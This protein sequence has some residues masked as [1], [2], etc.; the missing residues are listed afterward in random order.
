M[1]LNEVL[2]APLALITLNSNMIVAAIPTI[3][4]DLGVSVPYLLMYLVAA[5]L[6]INLI[7]LIPAGILGD[8]LGHK[9]ASIVGH[10]IIIISSTLVFGSQSIE[11][12]VAS[13]IGAAIGGSIL[14]PN[15]TAYIYSN[16]S[17]GNH[18]NNRTMSMISAVVGV[19][20][21]AGP[22]LGGIL[23]TTLGW[24]SILYINAPFF[25]LS[26][27]VLIF[28]ANKK[29]Q[30][31]EEL[32]QNKE[33]SLRNRKFSILMLITTSAII[34]GLLSFIPPI[35]EQMY[36]GK[37][38][39]IG[40]VTSTMAFCMAGS[41]FYVAKF[42]RANS[43]TKLLFTSFLLL[44][45]LVLLFSLFHQSILYIVITCIGV[46]ITAGIVF[47]IS[48]TKVMEISILAS[49]GRTAGIT[50]AL[51]YLGGIIGVAFVSL[52]LK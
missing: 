51:R 27:L 37:A 35:L 25:I 18:S 29:K 47:S 16:A 2:I 23:T 10:V 31:Y 42:T 14:V 45:F 11:V 43:N 44:I 40:A 1:K 22:F 32:P 6:L 50:G 12:V 30:K 41:A 33:M 28:A 39:I 38:T 7:F 46:G 17:V 20:V 34:Y 49:R 15:L 5:Y 52:V 13:R 9:N 3:S 48:Q 8:Y 21:A 24:A 4:L 36:A 26:M 19:S